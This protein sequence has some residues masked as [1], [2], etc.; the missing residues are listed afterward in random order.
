MECWELVG[1]RGTAAASWYPELDVE[2][3]GSFAHGLP[4]GASE[5]AHRTYF[6]VLIGSGTEK[7]PGFENGA[8][9]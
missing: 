3:Q 2:P 7:G 5:V 6:L 9:I 8:L 4:G 1:R